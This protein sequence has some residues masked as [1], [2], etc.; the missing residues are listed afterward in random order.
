MPLIDD[1]AQRAGMLGLAGKIS[2][3]DLRSMHEKLCPP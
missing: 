3:A 2:F 1:A